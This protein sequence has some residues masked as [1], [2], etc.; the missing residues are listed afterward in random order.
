MNGFLELAKRQL[1]NRTKARQRMAARVRRHGRRCTT[2]RHA[3]GNQHEPL[4]HFRGGGL[5][6]ILAGPH[7]RAA[8]HLVQFL[9]SMTVLDAPALIA[10]VKLGHWERTD[11][12]TRHEILSL[13]DDHLARLRVDDRLTGQD[14]I[15]FQQVREMLR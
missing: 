15:A 14:L 8:R 10:L 3:V 5:P 7:R 9:E 11:Q 2:V 1:S 12:N 4:R 6:R 13:I